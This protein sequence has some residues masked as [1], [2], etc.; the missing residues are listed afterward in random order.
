MQEEHETYVLREILLAL[1]I[2]KRKFFTKNSELF[3]LLY[4]IYSTNHEVKDIWYLDSGC[5]YMIGNKSY[6]VKKEENINLEVARGSK[7]QKVEG[8]G[9][10]Y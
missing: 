10:I 7:V 2:R 8:R 1:A 5:S 9:P 4:S 6:F 3:E